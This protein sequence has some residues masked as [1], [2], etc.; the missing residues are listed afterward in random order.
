MTASRLTELGWTCRIMVVVGNRLWSSQI[1][2]GVRTMIEG[3]G[4][5]PIVGG[6][7]IPDTPGAGRRS[8]M[9][10]GAVTLAL[11][12]FGLRDGFGRRHG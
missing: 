6:I 2:F 3:I 12:G 11:D 1:L 5:T 4:F 9:D 8:I 7:G 10:A